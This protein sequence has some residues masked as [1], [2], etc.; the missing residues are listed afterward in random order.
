MSSAA[1]SIEATVPAFD[2]APPSAVGGSDCLLGITVIL[3]FVHRAHSAA[4]LAR[5]TGWMA[6]MNAVG[7]MRKMIIV[8]MRPSRLAS[9]GYDL[10]S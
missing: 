2:G 5:S 10:S 4:L 1:R 8:I 6:G 7:V 3:P 9:A